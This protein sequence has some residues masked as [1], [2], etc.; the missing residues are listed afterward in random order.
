MAFSSVYLPRW[1]HCMLQ[2]PAQW[3]AFSTHDALSANR[4]RSARHA[5][6]RAIRAVSSASRAKALAL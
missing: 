4:E 6:M 1:R 3:V 5:I 2:A